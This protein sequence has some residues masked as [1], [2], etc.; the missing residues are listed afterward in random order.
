M[1]EVSSVPQV[2]ILAPTPLL[3]FFQP[4]IGARGLSDHLGYLLEFADGETEAQT[5]NDSPLIPTHGL[6]SKVS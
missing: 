6:P 1:S 4:S 2:S 5:G 3:P